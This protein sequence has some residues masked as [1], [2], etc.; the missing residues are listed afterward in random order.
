[1][2]NVSSWYEK[3]NLAMQETLSIREIMIL[4]SIGQPKAL[5][6]RQDVIEY[7]L[8]NNIHLDSKRVPTEIVFIVTHHDLNYYYEKMLLEIQAMKLK[9]SLILA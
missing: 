6:I 4:R 3:Y 8:A 1:M 5:K 7:C 9:Q 2:K